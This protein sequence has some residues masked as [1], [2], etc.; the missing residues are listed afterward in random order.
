MNKQA[1]LDYAPEALKQPQRRWTNT[2]LA[3]MIRAA[4]ALLACILVAPAAAEHSADVPTAEDRIFSVAPYSW[5][6]GIEGTTDRFS[7][8]P[9]AG[10]GMSFGGIFDELQPSGLVFFTANKGHLGLAAHLQYVETGAKSN[11]LAPLFGQERLRSTS[12]V[13]S[14]LSKKT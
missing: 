5:S 10:L 8:L 12:P 7:R 4:A 11:S 13:L 9:P 1:R 14:A 3:M 6:A 2:G